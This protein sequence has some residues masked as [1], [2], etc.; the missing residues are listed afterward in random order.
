MFALYDGPTDIRFQKLSAGDQPLYEGTEGTVRLRMSRF[1]PP[2]AVVREAQGGK[3]R[4]FLFVAWQEDAG[5]I[6]LGFGADPAFRRHPSERPPW[7]K[8]LPHG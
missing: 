5:R 8:S 7:L 6:S 2:E 3:P 4:R 1:M